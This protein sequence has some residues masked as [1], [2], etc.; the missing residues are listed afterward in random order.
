MRLPMHPKTI[1][2]GVAVVAVSF[3]ISL[4]A[5]DWLAPRGT[6]SRRCSSSCRR[7]RRRR[8]VPPCWRRSRLRCRRSATPPTA[9]RQAI[10]QRQGRQSD[11]A[12]PA[13]RRHRLDRFARADHR[14][15]RAGRTDAGDAADGNAQRHGLAVR[16]SHRRG[17][18]CARRPARRQCRQTDRQHQHQEP[19]RQRRDQGQCHDHRAAETRRQLAHR[20]E[21]WRRRLI[22]AIAALSWRAPAS[23][24]RR[25]SSR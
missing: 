23:T 9:A 13:E 2:I 10:L 24:C 5:M 14:H 17:R 21:S 8:A 19:Q 15:R 25:R 18:R 4:K 11:I 20:A 6:S 7:S 22:S 12:D 3:L 1:L 16:K